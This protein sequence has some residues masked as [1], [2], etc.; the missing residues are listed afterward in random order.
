[1]QQFPTRNMSEILKRC[2]DQ[3]YLGQSSWEQ[4]MKPPL[5]LCSWRTMTGGERGERAVTTD[6]LDAAVQRATVPAQGD[7]ERKRERELL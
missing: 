5:S 2:A 7:G 6:D 3:R 1:M 4:V